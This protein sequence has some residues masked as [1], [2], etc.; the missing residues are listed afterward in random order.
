MHAHR[1]NSNSYVKLWGKERSN[2][3]EHMFL[4]KSLSRKKVRGDYLNEIAFITLYASSE[5]FLSKLNNKLKFYCDLNNHNV[6][7][8]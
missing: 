8:Q 5:I 3:Y 7:W 6:M 1:I 2:S 4:A